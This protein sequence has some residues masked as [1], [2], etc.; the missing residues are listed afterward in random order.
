MPTLHEM[1]NLRFK[2][3]SK[4]ISLDN[5]SAF[6]TYVNQTYA[7]VS[8]Q[9][10]ITSSYVLVYWTKPQNQIHGI[11]ITDSITET[12]MDTGN[13]NKFIVRPALARHLTSYRQPAELEV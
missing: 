6:E 13:L 10:N 5:K 2:Y 3:F 9:M 11:F 1:A 7:T 8:D 4:D 12:I